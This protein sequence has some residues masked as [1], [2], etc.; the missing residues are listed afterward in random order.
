V[1]TMYMHRRLLLVTSFSL[2]KKCKDR[3]SGPSSYSTNH[4]CNCCIT[5][6]A[7]FAAMY[8]LWRVMAAVRTTWIPSPLVHMYYIQLAR[9]ENG[10]N[11]S[12]YCGGRNMVSPGSPSCMTLS[13]SI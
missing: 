7:V 13:S 1:C 10:S 9:H 5:P 12:A 3:R 11:T 4:N 8:V 6:V 2:I